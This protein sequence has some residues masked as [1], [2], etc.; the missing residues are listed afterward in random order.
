RRAPV[1]ITEEA[2]RGMHP[3]AVIVDMAAAQGGNCP[4]TEPDQVIEKDGVII[5]GI[6]NY[7]ALVPTDASAFYARNLFNLLSLMID[8]QGGL[9]ITLEDD[10]LESALVTYQGSVRYAG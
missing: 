4:L 3:G 1:L 10:I 7:P 6:T 9:S 5:I 2:V 8:E